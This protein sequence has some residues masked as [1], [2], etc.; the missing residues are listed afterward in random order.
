MS[1]TSSK[2][3]WSIIEKNND[4]DDD[5]HNNNKNNNNNK[6]INTDNRWISKTEFKKVIQVQVGNVHDIMFES[7]DTRKEKRNI[8]SA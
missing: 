1:I 7:N 4:N 5:D 8:A 3:K 2:K 6:N